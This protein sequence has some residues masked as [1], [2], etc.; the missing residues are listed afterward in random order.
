MLSGKERLVEMILQPLE[1]SGS[2]GQWLLDRVL[3]RLSSWQWIRLPERVVERIVVC[4][5]KGWRRPVC[6]CLEE[7]RR[8]T[9][10]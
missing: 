3:D 8:N 4:E 6:P 10:I 5:A 2:D 7:R 1:I 9:R